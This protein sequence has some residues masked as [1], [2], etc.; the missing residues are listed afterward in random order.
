M[1]TRMDAL[2]IFFF[3]AIVQVTGGQ[4]MTFGTMDECIQV[5]AQAANDPS[6]M[7]LSECTELKLTP[8]TIPK[9]NK[10]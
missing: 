4:G 2:V 8:V 10:S 7:F 6:V 5:R 9:E 3:L 1:E